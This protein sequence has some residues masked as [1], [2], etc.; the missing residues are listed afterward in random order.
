MRPAD[1]AWIALAA[2]VLVYELA[3]HDGELLSEAADRYLARHPVLTIGVVA[4]TALHLLNIT[5]R[6]CD[7]YGI[8]GI[9]RFER[10]GVDGRVTKFSCP[11]WWGRRPARRRGC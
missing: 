1:Q 9:S 2:G 10:R 4:A 5:P 11:R 3:A 6:W 8:L 7:P